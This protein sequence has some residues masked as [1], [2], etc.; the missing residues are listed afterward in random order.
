MTQKINELK[1]FYFIWDWESLIPLT[2]QPAVTGTFCSF[3]YHS[4]KA[5]IVNVTSTLQLLKA[6]QPSFSIVQKWRLS[7]CL[8]PFLSLFSS[9]VSLVLPLSATVNLLN[10]LTSALPT[11]KTFGARNTIVISSLSLFCLLSEKPYI[12][13]RYPP[14]WLLYLKFRVYILSVY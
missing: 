13:P 11:L 14:R 5:V 8:M 7:S 12:C 6:F 2:L 3:H 1:S 9:V 10:R 4:T